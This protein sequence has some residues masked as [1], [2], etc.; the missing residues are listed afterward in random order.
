MTS[1]APTSP[2]GE[3]LV[4]VHPDAETL[5]RATASRL[6][7][8]LLDAQSV[9]VPVHVA[10]T[11][12]T[13]GIQVLAAIAEDPLHTAIEWG[14]VHLWWGDERFLPRGDAER[15]E[16]QARE[17]LIDRLPIPVVNVH[18]VP[19]PEE[20]PDVHAAAGA[21]GA[22]IA[23][24]IGDEGAFTVVLLGVGP[25]GHVASLFPGSATLEHHG[26]GAIGE[27][28]S[29]KPP[30]ERVSLT[31]DTLR[32]AE[33]VWFVAAGEGKSA[34]VA[35]V[36]SGGSELPAAQVTGRRRTLWLLDVAAAPIAP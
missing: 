4:V 12:G 19:A 8:R 24:V 32:A 6:L 14:S 3:T 27:T 29:P 2:A 10:L 36:L 15:N 16:T 23:T 5:A 21:Y 9:N 25:D 33:E 34:A 28:D 30:P 26:P 13:V 18:P 35:E 7:V 20:T 1:T 22:E 17:A 11:G 31:L